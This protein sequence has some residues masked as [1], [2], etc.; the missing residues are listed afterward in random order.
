MSGLPVAAAAK[1]VICKSF[2]RPQGLCEQ[3]PWRWYPIPATPARSPMLASRGA[4][5]L[6]RFCFVQQRA[7][8]VV[9]GSH[10]EPTRRVAVVGGGISGLFC[11]TT[12][13]QYGYS[14][15][16]FDMGKSAPGRARAKAPTPQSCCTAWRTRRQAPHLSPRAAHAPAQTQTPRPPPHPRPPRPPPPTL[17]LLPRRPHD[18]AA[19]V[20]A[21]AA[22]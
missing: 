9:A 7:M 6:H 8:A 21:L 4:A 19:H 10:E 13:S 5:R 1:A 14:V 17:A 11:A 20:L 18:H 12:L 22:V 3:P 16:L 15:T 2:W